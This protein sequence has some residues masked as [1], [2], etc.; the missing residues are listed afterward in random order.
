VLVVAAAGN[1]A[2]NLKL[3]PAAY[4]EVIAVTATDE[5]DNPAGFTNFG[6][7]VELAAPGV[8]IYS[9]IWD[10]SYAYASGTSMATP[11]VSGVAALVWSRFPNMTR[12]QVRIQLRYTAD[13]LGYPGFDVHYGYGRINARKAVEFTRPDHDLR[14]VK[15]ERPPYLEPSDRAVIDGTIFNYGTSNES[16]IIVQFLVNG[17]LVGSVPISFLA[18]LNSTTVSVSWSPVV[19]GT[20]NVT[21]YIVPVSGETIIENNVQSST[22]LVLV[23]PEI[24]IVADDDALW[25]N[26]TSLPHFES[27][28]IATGYNYLVWNESTMGRPS[29]EFLLKFGLVI[30]TSGDYYSGAVDS[31]DEVTLETYF[32]RGGNILLEGEDIGYDHINDTFMINVAHAIYQVDKTDAPGLTV[33]DA[34]HPVTQ[35]LP[36]NFT[37]LEDP[38]YDDGVTPT[39]GGFEVIRYTNTSWT[40]VTVFDG[41]GTSYG[42]VVYYAFPLYCLAETER[43]TLVANSLSW[44]LL[45]HNIAVVDVKS[46]KN[47]VGQGYS[48]SINVTV[49]NHGNFTEAFNVTAYYGNGTVTSE[50]WETFWSMGDVNRDGY[51]NN[52]DVSLMNNALESRPGDPNWDPRCDLNQDEAVDYSDTIILAVGYGLDVWDYFISGGV[53]GTQTTS[54]LLKGT[55]A[56]LTLTWNTTSVARGNF[57]ISAHITPV[58]GETDTTDNN[59]AD[60]T[61]YVGFPGDLNGDREVDIFDAI[62]LSRAFGSTLNDHRWNPNADINGDGTVDIFDAIILAGNFGQID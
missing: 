36:T 29:S 56:N 28:L 45:H 38:L 24:L 62:I 49:E 2:T 40:A 27:A 43:N 25:L 16:G 59:F 4:D 61:V 15:L 44:L 7:W 13:D 57:T 46:S 14:L 22:V 54:N 10:N 20:Y 31:I 3:Y 37:W 47:I 42:S 8:G 51:I 55:S 6:D 17:S 23:V 32:A 39:N 12:D 60:G 35:G 48:V 34:A 58:L 26:G 5:Y 30:W 9:T 18:S 11:H 50:Q 1:E 53:I 52:V 21:F 33:T 19:E 41:E